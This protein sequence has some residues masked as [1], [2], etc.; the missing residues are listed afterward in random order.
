MKRIERSCRSKMLEMAWKT[1][2]IYESMEEGLTGTSPEFKIPVL[3]HGRT[4]P[5]Q[6][7][8]DCHERIDLGPEHVG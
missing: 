2:V 8:Q 3:L 5:H 7:A 1:L 4:H 6:F